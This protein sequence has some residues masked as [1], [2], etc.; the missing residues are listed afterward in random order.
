MLAESMK[1]F[2]FGL[3][4]LGGGFPFDVPDHP[5][6]SGRMDSRPP[7]ILGIFRSRPREV[8]FVS[9]LANEFMCLIR[10]P[11]NLED[12]SHLRLPKVN[13]VPLSTWS[14]IHSPA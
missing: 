3:G 1:Q 7:G 6:S 9:F 5:P 2:G 14:L 10:T 8:C 12:P 13:P 4:G 11:L